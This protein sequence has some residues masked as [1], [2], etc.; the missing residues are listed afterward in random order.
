MA[1]RDI[2]NA[3]LAREWKG[4]DIIYSQV[5]VTS[6][7]VAGAGTLKSLVAHHSVRPWRRRCTHGNRLIAGLPKEK[8]P[9]CL[10]IKRRECSLP[11]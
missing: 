10:R 1:T 4:R 8:P 2:F 9:P 7:D 6:D 11:T 5:H 3:L